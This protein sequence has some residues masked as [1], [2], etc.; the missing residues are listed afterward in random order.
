MERLHYILQQPMFQLAIFRAGGWEARASS[1]RP[2]KEPL[3]ISMPNPR[4]SVT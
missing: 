3:S 4:G 1:L 2:Q